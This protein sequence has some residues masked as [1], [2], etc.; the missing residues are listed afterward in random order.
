MLA[1]NSL[2]NDSEI[3]EQ[4]GF[5]NLVRGTFGMFRNP[6]G[7]AARITW[8]MTEEDAEDLFSTFP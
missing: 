3:S 2:S 7:H 8:Q 6:T 4:K 1:I 5:A